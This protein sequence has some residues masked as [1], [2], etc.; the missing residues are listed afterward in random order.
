MTF[1]KNLE[2][3]GHA[4]V[5]SRVKV[6]MNYGTESQPIHVVKTDSSMLIGDKES[7]PLFLS[8][9]KVRNC[10]TFKKLN[11]LK[12]KSGQFNNFT[13]LL[14]PVFCDRGQKGFFKMSSN[15][16]PNL[17]TANMRIVVSSKDP[18][19]AYFLR[20]LAQAG[21]VSS[22]EGEETTLLI[23][24]KPKSTGEKS[25]VKV[26]FFL[27]NQPKTRLRFIGI[28]DHAYDIDF[29]DIYSFDLST[30][31]PFELFR[32]QVRYIN[33]VSRYTKDLT[34]TQ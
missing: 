15:C 11:K 28:D 2:A 20:T 6:T 30:E 23:H 22:R 10:L 29:D 19:M 25:R 5:G 8:L 27:V 34:M 24:Y 21:F 32:I 33:G 9:P 3:L 17:P 13:P 7:T 31:S 4:L 18:N 14:T 12:L 1:N 26:K 16:P